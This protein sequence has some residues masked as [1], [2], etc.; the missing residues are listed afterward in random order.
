MIRQIEHDDELDEIK[1]L[2]ARLFPDCQPMPEYP[3]AVWWRSMCGD[4]ITAYAGLCPSH[5][6]ADGVYLCRAGVAPEYRGL[7]LQR[8]MIEVRER[9]ARK[10]GYLHAVTETRQ[11]IASSRNLIKCGYLPFNPNH[12]WAFAD[13]I[14][15][16]K[17]L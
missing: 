8:R 6:W 5:Q 15:W 3:D 9:W 2:D 4:R 1:E 10:H 11:N 12:P 7:G 17:T 13:S 14:Y 16:T